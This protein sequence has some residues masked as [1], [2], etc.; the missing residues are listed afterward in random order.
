MAGSG[1]E[2]RSRVEQRSG[3][4]LVVLGGLP[5]PTV[6]LAVLALLAGVTLLPLGPAALCLVVLAALLA[7]LSYLCWPALAA[8]DRVVRVLGLAVLLVLGVSALG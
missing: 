8:R 2:L 7:W 1:G 3:P 4:L 6:G 5:R